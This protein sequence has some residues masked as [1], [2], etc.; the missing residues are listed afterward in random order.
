[1]RTKMTIGLAL[2]LVHPSVAQFH[3]STIV[4]I[5]TRT[6]EFVVADITA[7]D[8]AECCRVPIDWN[9]FSSSWDCIVHPATGDVIVGTRRCIPC[10]DHILRLR[11]DGTLLRAE[12]WVALGTNRG[13]GSSSGKFAFDD[14]GILYYD[15]VSLAI[16]LDRRTWSTIPVAQGGVEHLVPVKGGRPRVDVYYEYTPQPYGL[17]RSIASRDSLGNTAQVFARE[18]GTILSVGFLSRLVTTQT[19]R[20]FVLGN[21]RYGGLPALWELDWN[22]G[23]LVRFRFGVFNP[24]G[25]VLAEGLGKIYCDGFQLVTL[26]TGVQR[27]DYGMGVVDLATNQLTWSVQRGGTSYGMDPSYGWF[28]QNVL[29]VFPRNPTSGL[30]FHALFSMGGEPGDRGMIVA[31]SAVVG[32]QSVV[33]HQVLVLGTMNPTGLVKTD[34]AYDPM[35]Y[36]MAPGD[37]LTFRGF[38]YDGNELVVTEPKT[39][40]WR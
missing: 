27:Y 14:E 18:C 9:G 33:M 21:L 38:R 1:M 12:S 22:T 16:D 37:S 30:P 15:G 26:P 17:C 34:F 28:P 31:T 4:G 29:T 19:G 13:L 11:W 35:L 36:P 39:V 2:L 10:E 5:D 24:S 23:T 7:N 3:P 20:T 40:T 32:G 25:Y 6:S 8:I